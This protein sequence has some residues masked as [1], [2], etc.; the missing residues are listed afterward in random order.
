LFEFL[1][2]FVGSILNNLKIR[3]FSELRVIGSKSSFKIG[4][5]LKQT[6][7]SPRRCGGAAGGSRA[8]RQCPTRRVCRRVTQI[9]KPRSRHRDSLLSQ[10][11]SA[12]GSA[13]DG[14][15]PWANKTEN[16]TKN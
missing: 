1:T 11:I 2:D 12:N 5:E 3:K 8:V 13:S 15:Q 10:R 14:W 6:T 9:S 16:R 4:Y 7:Y